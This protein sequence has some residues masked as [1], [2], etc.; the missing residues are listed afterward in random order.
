ML[1]KY[2]LLFNLIIL[3]LS[4]NAQRSADGKIII[5]KETN[6]IE[7]EKVDSIQ[8][9]GTITDENGDPLPFAMV[10][11]FENEELITGTQT[12]FDGKYILTLVKN[13]GYVLEIKYVGLKEKKFE[14]PLGSQREIVVNVEFQEEDWEKGTSCCFGC[15]FGS[16]IIDVSNTTS[17][18]TLEA[19]D[20]RNMGF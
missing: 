19:N 15:Y 20:L 13:I 6:A 4:A 18:I 7:T 5:N 9:K 3:C 1:Y 11:L 8:I 14:V 16:T 2:I 10:A 17:G 12:N